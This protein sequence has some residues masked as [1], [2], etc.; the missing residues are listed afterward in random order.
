MATTTQ[1]AVELLMLAFPGTEIVSVSE[2]ES[3]QRPR[4]PDHP[5]EEAA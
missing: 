2:P 5:S 3:T 1:D 4:D